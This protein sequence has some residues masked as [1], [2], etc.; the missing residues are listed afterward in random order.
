MHRIHRSGPKAA[1][2]VALPV[3]ETI[4]G[5]IGFHLSDPFQLQCGRVKG[6]EMLPECQDQSAGG[7]RRNA[8][9]DLR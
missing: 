7:P 8:S 6:R 4:V 1:L 2:R 3:I 9:D 5:Q